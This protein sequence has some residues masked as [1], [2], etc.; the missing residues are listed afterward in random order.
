MDLRVNDRHVRKHAFR[1]APAL[2]NRGFIHDHGRI[3][4]LRARVCNC[5][6]HHCVQGGFH[7]HLVTPEIH[8]GVHVR[9]SGS[10]DDLAA[11]HGR[12]AAECHD[13]LNVIAAA[14]SCSFLHAFNSRIG[15]NVSHFKDRC[16]GVL[17]EALDFC[18]QAVRPKRRSCPI[19]L[20][21]PIP[22]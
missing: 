5:G 22:K 8:A 11:V 17:N 9:H 7:F 13:A 2:R 4:Q 19:L 20:R 15:V 16:A 1:A 14:D 10:R 3:V 21:S 18:V 12:A 6:D